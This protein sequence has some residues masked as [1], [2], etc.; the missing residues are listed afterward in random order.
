VWSNVRSVGYT[1]FP[2]DG[3]LLSDIENGTFVTSGNYSHQLTIHEG[4]ITSLF[5]VRAARGFG[6]G[7]CFATDFNID[8]GQAADQCSTK[9]VMY[10]E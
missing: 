7:P 4:K 10:A 1:N 6:D 8:H 3:I 5:S 2:V 9:R